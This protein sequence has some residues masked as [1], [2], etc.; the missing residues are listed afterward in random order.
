MS[1][2]D[3]MH[4]AWSNREQAMELF[5]TCTALLKG[6]L[7]TAFGSNLQGKFLEAFVEPKATLALPVASSV[8][9]Q[10]SLAMWSFRVRK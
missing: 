4:M 5:Q 10:T 7:F 3:G 9:P 6:N 2:T 8:E 1:F